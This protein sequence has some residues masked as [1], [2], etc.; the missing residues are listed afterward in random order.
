MDRYLDFDSHYPL[1][2]KT[3]VVR[4]LQYRARILSSS[5]NAQ[6][7]EESHLMDALVRNGYPRNLVHQHMRDCDR[8]EGSAD[9]EP[10]VTVFASHM[11][12]E[13]QKS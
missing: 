8:N 12:L 5:V 10:E 1:I 3:A 4:M 6:R 9:N 13:S 11:S 7:D 2:H